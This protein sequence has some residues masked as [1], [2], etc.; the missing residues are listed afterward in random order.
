MKAP[1]VPGSAAGVSDAEARDLDPAPYDVVVS[2]SLFL[3]LSDDEHARHE[4]IAV[5]PAR[6]RSRAA[7]RISAGAPT[8]SPDQSAS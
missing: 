6:D 4:R 2:H 3:Y 5:K 8:R 1:A 7:R